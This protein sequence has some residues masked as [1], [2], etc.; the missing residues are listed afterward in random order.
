[1]TPPDQDVNVHAGR[2]SCGR[3]LR[4]MSVKI[5]AQG[6]SEVLADGTEGEIVI[7]GD[8]IFQGYYENPGATGEVLQGDEFR[9]GDLGY[10]HEG[11]L[12]V[13][14]RI[15][16]IIILDGVNVAP[17]ELEWIADPIVMA[18]GRA[19]AFSIE[20]EGREV[21]VLAVEVRDV[22]SPEAIEA[23]RAQVAQDIAPLHDLVL[24]RRGTLP[25]TSSGKVKRLTVKASYLDGTLE[26]LWSLREERAASAA[27]K[28]K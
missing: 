6:S 18:G 8:A 11:E 1:M 3:P 7:S 24:V 5:C 27:D 4:T 19:G 26:V 21:P 15:K 14:G 13:T 9:S 12:Y 23:V 28:V 25:K 2:V 17:Y 16:D 10:V 20:L 22:P